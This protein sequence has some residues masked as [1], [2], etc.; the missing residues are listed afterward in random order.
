MRKWKSSG[1]IS[2]W[3]FWICLWMKWTLRSLKWSKRSNR[4]QVQ[5]LWCNE[6]LPHKQL[7]VRFGL[8]LRLFY[9]PNDLLS[10][11]FTESSILE[12]SC[13][14]SINW[15]WWYACFNI[16]LKGFQ[17]NRV[18]YPLSA[19][20]FTISSAKTHLQ[21]LQVFAELKI[22][23][24][25]VASISPLSIT[26]LSLFYWCLYRSNIN[27]ND[28]LGNYSL[29]LIDTLDTL[30]VRFTQP[31]CLHF[32]HSLLQESLLLPL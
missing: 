8:I 9:G 25:F 26:P 18:R 7:N 28:V 3:S 31:M 16:L 5:L 13:S 11:L 14:C 21:T 23:S 12:M 24:W 19:A 32:T 15:M 4:L 1:H 30:L 20:V 17:T 27:I 2:T 29:T 10:E 6:L 22:G